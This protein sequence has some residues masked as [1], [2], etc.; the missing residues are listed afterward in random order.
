MR[1]DYSK[2]VRDEVI[3]CRGGLDSV[4]HS[5]EDRVAAIARENQG[6]T[7]LALSSQ[8]S[9]SQSLHG[10]TTALNSYM[11]A[12]PSTRQ[13]IFDD[14]C[15]VEDRQSSTSIISPGGVYVVPSKDLATTEVLDYSTRTKRFLSQLTLDLH[16][17]E[18][19][20]T[21][22]LAVQ[23]SL[24]LSTASSTMASTQN[25]VATEVNTT[26]AELQSRLNE[27]LAC[28]GPSAPGE[29]TSG[30]SLYDLYAAQKAFI[31]AQQQSVAATQL[32]LASTIAQY[33]DQVAGIAQTFTAFYASIAGPNGLI[34]QFSNAVGQL[35]VSVNTCDLTNPSWCSLSPDYWAIT[36]PSL[37]FAVLQSIPSPSAV[38]QTF[39]AE[40]LPAAQAA[41]VASS[42]ALVIKLEA[43]QSDALNSVAV[44]VA[45]TPLAGISK[46]AIDQR[47]AAQSELLDVCMHSD[48]Y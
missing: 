5:E 1:E 7:D 8:M 27:V 34:S 4:L 26:I 40:T 18:N 9:C 19:N 42:T 37:Q 22:A 44:A 6:V 33:E 45:D 11:H 38:W 2:C 15:S 41:M 21:S 29:C 12:G 10:I 35:G 25:A 13:I 23:K 43:I 28:V 20:Y 47:V 16:A 30:P 36:A 48:C 31:D 3:V 17:L 14:A 32:E 39:T 24:M 46:D